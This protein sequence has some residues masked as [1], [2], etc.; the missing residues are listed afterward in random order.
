MA[1][2]KFQGVIAPTTPT[3]CKE[4]QESQAIEMYSKHLRLQIQ[5]HCMEKKV[6]EEYPHI[7]W[8]SQSKVKVL[9]V[10]ITL[11]QDL[12]NCKKKFLGRCGNAEPSHRFPSP[13][14]LAII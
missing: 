14:S 12:E 4:N 9:Q 13:D 8:N 3:G 6:H 11:L 10:H 1:K 7:K 5:P 2:G